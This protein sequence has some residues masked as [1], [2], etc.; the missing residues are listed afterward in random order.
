MIVTLSRAE[1]ENSEPKYEEP[2]YICFL[3]FSKQNISGPH[4]NFVYEVLASIPC[5]DQAKPGLYLVMD[6]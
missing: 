3:P 2:I 6:M 5:K 4:N 1:A